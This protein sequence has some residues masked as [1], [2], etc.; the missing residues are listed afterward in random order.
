MAIHFWH[1]LQK[2]PVYDSFEKIVHEWNIGHPEA[3]VALEHFSRYGDSAEAAL[4]KPQD[5]Q[6]ALILA[7][8]FMTSKMMQALRER[9]IIPINRLL[10]DGLQHKITEIVKRTFG[11]R[12]GNIVSLPFNPACG[13]I[14]TNKSVLKA[15]GRDPD[16]VPA[17]LEQLEEVCRELVEKKLVDQGYTCAWPAAYLVEVPA[18]QQNIPLVMPENGKRGYGEYLLSSPWLLNHF[19]DLRQQIKRNVFTY[20][21]KD[22]N[23]RQPFVQGKVAFFL[24]GSSHFQWLKSEVDKTEKPFEIGF[25]PVPALVRG[26]K[27]KYAF[28][29]GGA[30]VWVLDS[31]ESQ[32]MIEGVR[33]FLNYLASEKILTQWHLEN[34]SVPVLKSIPEKLEIFY[35]DHPLHKMVVMQTLEAVLGANCLGVQPVNYAKAREEMFNL[36]EKILNPETPEYEIEGLLKN[37]DEKFTIRP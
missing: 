5:Q 25:G 11:D 14:F 9:K 7:P 20:V 2:G 21:C 23:A 24:Q 31:A 17:T 36:I 30:A 15:S 10:N 18:A 27:E 1:G 4:A 19:L 35:Q 22:N 3:Q 6:P 28:P 33:A 8:E 34:Q 16:L 26:L 13:V 29:L 12:D 37:F 32:K